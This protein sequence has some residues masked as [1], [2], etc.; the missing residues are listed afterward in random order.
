MIIR[1]TVTK[2]TSEKLFKTN[3]ILFNATNL[4]SQPQ[5]QYFTQYFKLQ[6]Q[7]ST[8]SLIL[9]DIA[10]TSKTI[11]LVETGLTEFLN[12]NSQKRDKFIYY[13]DTYIIRTVPKITYCT[14]VCLWANSSLFILY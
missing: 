13:K 1:I 12:A 8:V 6:M 14:R 10:R 3:I 4:K 5:C 11:I 2:L 7:I 9:L